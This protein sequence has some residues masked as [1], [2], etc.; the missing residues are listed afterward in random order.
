MGGSRDNVLTNDPAAKYEHSLLALV[1]LSEELSGSSGLYELADV[2]LYNLMGHFGAS[3][4][5][6]WLLATGRDDVA[7]LVR[8]HGIPK[9][10]ARGMGVAWARW[11]KRRS[12]PPR[13]IL[14]EDFRRDGIGGEELALAYQHKIAVLAPI[15]AG[16]RILG[17]VAV[18][19]RLGGEPYTNLDVG[20]MRA[21]L[22]LL[23]VAL[24]NTRLYNQLFE[25]H[26]QLQEAN[27]RMSEADEMKSEFLRNLNHELRTP[28]TI[29]TGYLDIVAER[30]PDA[31]DRDVVRVI[32]EQMT[33]L[34]GMLVNLLELSK[35]T[36]ASTVVDFEACDI[37]AFVETYC[38]RR[39]P[40]VAADLR[41]LRYEAVA[42]LPAAWCSQQQLARAL[43]CVVDNAVKFT[44]QGACIELALA[45]EPGWLRLD[46]TDNGPGMPP[47]I[48][49]AIFE[50]FRQGDGSL[51]RQHGGMGVGLS[52]AKQLVEQMG[53]RIAC[54]SQL[55]SGTTFS[56]WLST[57]AVQSRAA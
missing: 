16:D 53:G 36:D 1:E 51:T 32:R 55:G 3:R 48:Y 46:V 49:A 14:V 5:G 37:G 47:D 4:I 40:G 41:D 45:V 2:A 54:T 13:P 12:G 17:F 8:G 42:D 43:D 30:V 31:E 18:G 56:I 23:G 21:S 44:Q 33:K 7:V 52:V 28:L 34:E 20:L 15:A 24:D 11:F 38:E 57:E 22:G 35:M 26:R 9:N 19:A 50:P 10:V 29:M 25:N 6:L 39:R 27:R